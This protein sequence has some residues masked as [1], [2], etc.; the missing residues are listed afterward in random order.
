LQY[1]GHPIANDPIYANQR[2]F[3]PSLGRGHSED[4]NDEDIMTRL[5]R[6]GKE[7]V[8]DA[9]A[10]HDE[11]VDQYN[12]RKAEKMTGETCDVCDTPLY[13]DPGVHE[14]GIYL[15]ARRYHCGEGKWDYQTDLPEWALPPPDTEGPTVAT[16]ESDPLAVDLQK[17][18]LEESETKDHQP[19]GNSAQAQ[20]PSV[21]ESVAAAAAA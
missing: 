8:A 13:S 19:S 9:V 11:M 18:G 2:V 14:L 15:H 3:G 5:S 20:V 21:E 6:M 4:E 1:L 7:E 12:K 16:D 10:Y 17:L